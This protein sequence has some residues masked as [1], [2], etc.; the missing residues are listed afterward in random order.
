MASNFLYEILTHKLCTQFDLKTFTDE[1]RHH[2]A[3][4]A[5]HDKKIKVIAYNALLQF[6]RKKLIQ[7]LTPKGA[8]NARFRKL[9]E[10]KEGEQPILTTKVLSNTEMSQLELHIDKLRD[11]NYKMLNEINIYKE[12]A[13]AF[14]FLSNSANKKI[15]LHNQKIKHNECKKQ[16]IDDLIAESSKTTVQETNRI[17]DFSLSQRFKHLN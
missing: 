4:S 11:D 3:Y 2:S 14:P 10:N 15:E 9:F 12:L 13:S 1:V 5:Y 17:K 6:E 7:R 16:I 8:Y